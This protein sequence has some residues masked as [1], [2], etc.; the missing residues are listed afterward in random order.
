[1]DHSDTGIIIESSF[2]HEFFKQMYEVDKIINEKLSTSYSGLSLKSFYHQ[3]HEFRYGR[4]PD[5]ENE[6]L[7]L[8]SILI[9]IHR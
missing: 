8:D 4:E 6:F 3:R 9:Q 5:N 2:L 7:I 1:M